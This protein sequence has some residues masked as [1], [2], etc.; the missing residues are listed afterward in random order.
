MRLGWRLGWRLVA[1]RAITRQLPDDN[2]HF[3]RSYSPRGGRFASSSASPPPFVFVLDALELSVWVATSC[4]TFHYSNSALNRKAS[5]DITRV[6]TRLPD[7]EL[8]H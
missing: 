3:S 2:T 8:S 1:P 6:T 7:A 5:G 4:F